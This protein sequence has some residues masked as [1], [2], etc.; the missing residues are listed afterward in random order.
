M[1]TVQ[2]IT[3]KVLVTSDG[4]EFDPDDQA[5]AHAHQAAINFYQLIKNSYGDC[6]ECHCSIQPD[7]IWLFLMN[8]RHDVSNLMLM[9]DQAWNEGD[10]G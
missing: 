6:R 7:D 2:S 1:K 9:A 3:K 5:Q 4:K 8:N 10:D